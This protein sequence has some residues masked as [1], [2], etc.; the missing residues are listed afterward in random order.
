MQLLKK[1]SKHIFAAILLTCLALFLGLGLGLSAFGMG[2]ESQRFIN[3][4]DAMI[5]R[6]IPQGK[7]VLDG[8]AEPIG[9]V[10]DVYTAGVEILR[11]AYQQDVL[12]TL[13]VEQASDQTVVD[14][15]K[16]YATDSFE[17]DWKARYE[18]K[19]DLD[20]NEF[21]HALVRFDVKVAKEF[22]DYSFTHSGLSWI[23]KKGTVSQLLNN[24]FPKSGLYQEA[25]KNETIVD[26]TD[27]KSGTYLVNNKVAFINNQITGIV[28]IAA[29]PA[30]GT[31]LKDAQGTLDTLTLDG[32]KVNPVQISAND[33]YHPTYTVMY[34][35]TRI[36]VVFLIILTPMFGMFMVVYTLISYEVFLRMNWSKN[37]LS[38]LRTNKVPQSPSIE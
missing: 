35:Q 23:G 10:I 36:G 34:Y 6:Y 22:H 7:V 26:Q 17:Q 18:A 21:S 33:L 3:S 15:F 12:S 24:N 38:K 1:N 31:V 19:E 27:Y 30:L 32:T 29:D 14:F 2:V 13:T 9:G 8:S 16:A 37:L 4:V 20:V 28:N 25:H 11:E 5:D